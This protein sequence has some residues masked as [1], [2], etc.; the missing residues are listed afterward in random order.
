MDTISE[1]NSILHRKKTTQEFSGAHHGNIYSEVWALG[2]PTLVNERC[3]VLKG[4]CLKSI[5]GLYFPIIMN[6]LPALICF[7]Q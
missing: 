3:A 2:T 5:A 6:S 4:H 1:D 7:F